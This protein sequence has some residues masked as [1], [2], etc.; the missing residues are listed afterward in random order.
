MKNIFESKTYKIYDIYNNCIISTFNTL[1]ELLLFISKYQISNEFSRYVPGRENELG[2]SNIYLDNVN[3]NFKD[4]RVYFNNGEKIFITRRYVFFDICNNIIDIRLYV[5]KIIEYSKNISIYNFHYNR[6]S[7]Y[8]QVI[9][10]YESIPGIH[11]RTHH[12]GSVYRHPKVMNEKRQA[13]NIEYKEY[14]KPSRNIKNIPNAWDDN[15]RNFYKSWKSQSKKK[16][17]WM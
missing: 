4:S 10:R 1:E 17:Q 11:K 16:K 13:V 3:M 6:K 15:V 9:F 8:K 7:Q 2:Y 5:D 14:V 12:R